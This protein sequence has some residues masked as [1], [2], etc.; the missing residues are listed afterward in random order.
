V[1]DYIHAKLL[2]I[3]WDDFKTC[4]EFFTASTAQYCAI[5]ERYRESLDALSKEGFEKSR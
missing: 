1:R 3:P 4:G 5:E 2:A